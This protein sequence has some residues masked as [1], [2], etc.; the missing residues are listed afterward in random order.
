MAQVLNAFLNCWTSPQKK[1]GRRTDFERISC[2]RMQLFCY[3]F[4]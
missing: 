4:C 1:D 3:R 2:R